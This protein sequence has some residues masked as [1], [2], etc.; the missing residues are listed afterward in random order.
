VTQEVAAYALAALIALLLLVAAA[1][2]VGEALERYAERRRE[3]AFERFLAGVGERYGRPVE[4]A[5]GGERELD[6]EVDAA[7]AA[8]Q[9]RTALT[10]LLGAGPAASEYGGGRR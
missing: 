7:A 1:V 3:R 5:P 9:R 4:R 10:A 2:V 6:R 8:R